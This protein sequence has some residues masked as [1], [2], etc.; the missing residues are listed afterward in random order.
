MNIPERSTTVRSGLSV[1]LG[2]S[3]AAEPTGNLVELPVDAIVRNEAQPRTH[4]DRDAI[5]ALAESIEAQGLIQPIAVRRLSDT[6]YEIVAGERR[7][8]AAQQAGL[9]TLPAIVHDVDERAALILA[10]VE[11]VVRQDLS[12]LE[13]AR[14][15]AALQDTWE[16]STAEL[17]RALGKSRPAVANTMRLLELPDDVLAAL[18]ARRLSEGHGRALLGLPE[19]ADQRRFARRAVQSGMSVRA[20]ESAVRSHVER[21]AR[22]DSALRTKWNTH[23][24]GELQSRVDA[25]SNRLPQGIKLRVKT[26]HSGAKLELQC[27]SSV[28]LDELLGA[29]ER[30]VSPGLAAR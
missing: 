18:D 4:F 12:P 29:L 15:Y 6:T 23:P 1:L 3:P 19:R 17:A 30:L 28:A 9:R 11:N 20:L 25:I 22:G 7:W 26:G 10:L 13:T 16:V 2:G 8:L 5:A 24:D 21:D 14:A 27:S